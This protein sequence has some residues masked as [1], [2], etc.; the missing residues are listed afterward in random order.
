M[1]KHSLCSQEVCGQ[2][3]K[4]TQTP[5][6]ECKGEN[7]VIMGKDLQRKKRLLP[8]TEVEYGMR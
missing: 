6:L 2:R 3:R 4:Q 8:E 5:V 1:N 7:S